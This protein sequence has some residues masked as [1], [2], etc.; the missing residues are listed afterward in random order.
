MGDDVP[1]RPRVALILQARR[2]LRRLRSLVCQPTIFDLFGQVAPGRGAATGRLRRTE[3]QRRRT[4][5]TACDDL[6]PV[7]LTEG[8]DFVSKVVDAHVGSPQWSNTLLLVTYD[9]RGG[10]FDHVPP[11]GTLRGHRNSSEDP[12]DPS[13]GADHLGVR[14]PA[15]VASPRVEPGRAVL[16]TPSPPAVPATAIRHIR[17]VDAPPPELISERGA[18]ASGRPAGGVSHVPGP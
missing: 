18:Q 5:S 9:E 16:N 10:F 7:D 11:P 17:P 14:V 3:L 13:R 4:L 1:Y 8:Q 15:L 12:E 2:R 6:C